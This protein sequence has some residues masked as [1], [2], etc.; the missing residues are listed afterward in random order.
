MEL[1]RRLSALVIALSL[2]LPQ[3]SCLSGGA[4]EIHYPLSSADSLL[5]VI[6]IALL[7]SLPLITLLFIRFPKSS[8][9]VGMA[10]VAA[11]LYLVSY[12]ASLAA[13]HL[14]IGWYS[15]TFAAIVYFYASLVRLNR[16]LSPQVVPK[17]GVSPDQ[18][19]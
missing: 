3:R 10:A 2:A 12:G 9:V 19:Q 17:A 18:L 7:Y 4:T 6:V 13:D 5:S 15:Y 11:G 8:L 16:L 14:L 1:V